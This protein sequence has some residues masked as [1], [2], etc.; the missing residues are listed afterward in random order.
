MNEQELRDKWDSRY[1]ETQ[2]IPP[3]LEV[4]R[5]HAYLLPRLGTALDLACGL[6][7]SAIFMAEQGLETWAWDQS[8][9]AIRALAAAADDLALHAQIRDVVAEPPEFRRFDVICVGHFLDRDLCSHIAAALKPG[10]L[11][12]YQTWI[13]DKVDDSGPGSQGF[14]L[15]QNELLQLFPG[16]IV[17]F[18]Q[19][20][21]R[22]GEPTQGFRNRAQ[23]IAQ[24]AG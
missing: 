1:T 17:R 12:F 20:L 2:A 23:L 21:G 14:R 16:L 5:E 3:P 11:L 9:V 6:G 8:P 22:V 19:D 18:Y 13:R 4:L 15:A 10:G 24:S 7:G